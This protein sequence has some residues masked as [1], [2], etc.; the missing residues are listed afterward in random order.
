MEKKH[1]L[2]EI[3]EIL[4]LE[5]TNINTETYIEIDSMASLLL[6][7]F[8]DENFSKSISQEKIKEIKQIK[9]LINFV[10]EDNLE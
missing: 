5:E 6:I 10:G 1:F 9:D 2:E 8:F 7:A 4:L 3:K